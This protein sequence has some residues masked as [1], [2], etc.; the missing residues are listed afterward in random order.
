MREARWVFGTELCAE[1]QRYVLAAYVH[2]FTKDHAPAWAREP[3]KDGKA[4][5]VQYASDRDW[6]AHAR[7]Q[8]RNDGRLD[9]RV[10]RCEGTPTWPDNP[11]LRKE[12]T[13]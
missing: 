5:P 4:Y 7:F 9:R 11:E 6:L 13:P 2:R 10:Q 8:V 3:W 12:V 1:D